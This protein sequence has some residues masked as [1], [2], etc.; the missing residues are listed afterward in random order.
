VGHRGAVASTI[1][2]D[3]SEPPHRRGDDLPE[4]TDLDL[5]PVIARPDGVFV[6]DARVKAAPCAPQDPFL[7]KLR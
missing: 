6:V 4:V 7:R 5:N 2:D 1:A 3:D